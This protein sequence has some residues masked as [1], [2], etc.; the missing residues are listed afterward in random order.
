MDPYFLSVVISMC[1][2]GGCLMVLPGLSSS[3]IPVQARLFAA[4][5]IAV[6]IAAFVPTTGLVVESSTD[7]LALIGTEIFIGLFM[8]LIGRLFLQALGFMAT[9]IGT[10]I[11]YGNI[12]GAGIEDGEPHAAIGSLITMAAIVVLLNMDFHHAVI[13]ALVSSYTLMPPLEPIDF[14][15]SL[16]RITHVLATGFMITLQL[17]S[18]FIAYALIA[19]L[20][21]GLINKL[22]PQVPVYFVSLPFLIMGGLWFIYLSMPTFLMRF[23]DAFLEFYR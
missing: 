14:A 7:L 16:E 6:A 19:N 5:G 10:V 17:A 15:F 3:R 21:I 9:T 4:I 20:A 8:G 23:A 12:V 2:V 11:G 18:P 22:A 13:M 1:R